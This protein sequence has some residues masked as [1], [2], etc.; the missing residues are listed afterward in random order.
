MQYVHFVEP[1]MTLNQKIAQYTSYYGNRP[2]LPSSNF[3]GIWTLAW[4]MT[5]FRFPEKVC[6]ALGLELVEIRL[7]TF[8]VKRPFGQVY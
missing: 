4:K 8:S 3:K 7:N 1:V 2:N 5:S 6:C